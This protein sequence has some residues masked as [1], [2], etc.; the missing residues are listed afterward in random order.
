VHLGEVGITASNTLLDPG[1][2]QRRE[3]F[4]NIVSLGTGGVVDT[5]RRFSAREVDLTN[6]DLELSFADI[7]LLRR[8]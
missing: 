4:A 6:R 8:G 1:L 3:T 2:S 7:D 5:Q